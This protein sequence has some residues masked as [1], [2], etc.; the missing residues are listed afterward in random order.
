MLIVARELVLITLVIS[1]TNSF[2]L[3]F[4]LSSSRN[5]TVLNSKVLS[6]AIK[7]TPASL[8]A[9]VVVEFSHLYNVSNLFIYLKVIKYINLCVL[10]LL[11]SHGDHVI[12]CV[13]LPLG[14]YQPDLYILG[15][16]RQVRFAILFIN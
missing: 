5:S 14:H 6:V 16:E 7:P 4:F 15:R 10:L 9:P 3:F 12:L 11:F 2:Q 13:P 1:D 8:S